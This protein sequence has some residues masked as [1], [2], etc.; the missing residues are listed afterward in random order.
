MAMTQGMASNSKEPLFM[1]FNRF[2]VIQIFLSFFEGM[3]A[4]ALDVRHEQCSAAW[5]NSSFDRAYAINIRPLHARGGIA[6]PGEKVV[7]GKSSGKRSR[8]KWNSYQQ[9][10]GGES[11]LSLI[12][13]N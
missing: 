7:Y 1:I 2:S 13:L 3:G 12:H 10:P 8:F 4:K 9:L 11:R 5:S 6:W